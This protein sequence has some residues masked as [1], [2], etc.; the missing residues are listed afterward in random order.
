[1]AG[2]APLPITAIELV[3]AVDSAVKSAENEASRA[4]DSLRYLAKQ[5]VTAS[6]LG[7]TGAGKKM[8]KLA[9]SDNSSIAA[10]AKVVVDSWK[11]S[12]K[13]DQA[14]AQAAADAALEDPDVN[15]PDAVGSGTSAKSERQRSAPDSPTAPSP[16]VPGTGQWDAAAV[17]EAASASRAS[18][19]TEAK[20]QAAAKSAIARTGVKARDKMRELL[21]ESLAMA[22]PEV[23]NGRPAEVAGELESSLLSWGGGV[24]AK[25]KAKFRTISFNLKDIGNPDLRRRVLSHEILPDDLLEMEAED[26]ASDARKADNEKIRQHALWDAERGASKK[27]T[28]DQFQCGKCRQRQCTYYQMQTRSADEPMTTFVSCLNCEHRWKFC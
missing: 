8:N 20:N 9:K 27:A 14:I 15:R 19:K 13:R 3:K 17:E 6:T 5:V 4:V 28:T 11:E 2:I 23:A 1:M 7:A 26:L 16:R 25:Y 12:I 18:P 21:A 22:L 10:A 24:T